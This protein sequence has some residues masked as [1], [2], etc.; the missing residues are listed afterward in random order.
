MKTIF[1]KC[2]YWPQGGNGVSLP[3]WSTGDRNGLNV[4]WAKKPFDPWPWTIITSQWLLTCWMTLF[5][6]YH[7]FKRTVLPL[8]QIWDMTNRQEL[9]ISD[10]VSLLFYKLLT[11]H[12]HKRLKST[13]T[14]Y[15]KSLC[16]CSW[17]DTRPMVIAQTCM[18]MSN[19]LEYNIISH[20][21]ETHPSSCAEAHWWVQSEETT[22]L[23]GSVI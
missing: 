16:C 11:Q 12:I 18:L 13:S 8:S 2:L 3:V 15:Y 21:T 20:Q 23:R 10:T 17:G 14:N 1:I 19:I 9:W 22:V 5:I 6:Y 4:T 7:T